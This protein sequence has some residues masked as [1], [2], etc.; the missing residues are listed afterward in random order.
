MHADEVT[1]AERLREAGYRTGIF[2]KWH[3]GDNYPMRPMDQGFEESLI[4][5]SG[6]INQTPDRPNDLFRSASLEE[7]AA[8]R[9][10]GLLHRCLLRR[11]SGVHR[12]EQR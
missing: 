7:R 11:R 4:H 2:G 8:V 6:G 3:L 10:E 12:K 9:S 1:L 5:K